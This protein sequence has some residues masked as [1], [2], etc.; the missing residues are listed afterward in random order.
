[1]AGAWP[2]ERNNLPY[3]NFKGLTTIIE[4]AN[5][6]LKVNM[7]RSYAYFGIKEKKGK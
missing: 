4:Y 6:A 3:I 2:G 5:I 1:M 7:A